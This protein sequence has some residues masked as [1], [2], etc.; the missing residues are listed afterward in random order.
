MLEILENCKLFETNVAEFSVYL[1][2]MNLMGNVYMQKMGLTIAL[3]KTIAL[4]HKKSSKM[5]IT[6]PMLMAVILIK[7][8]RLS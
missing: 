8:I 1:S 7:N 5:L 3:Y 4:F 2:Y 6:K